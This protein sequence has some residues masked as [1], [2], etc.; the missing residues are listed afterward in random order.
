RDAALSPGRPAYGVGAGAG[1]HPV[2]A[3][4]RQHGRTPH[5]QG[6]GRRGDRRRRPHRRERR[7]RKQDRHLPARGAGETPWHSVL[8]RRALLHF[9]SE[10]P[11]RLPYSY[12]GAPGRRGP[13]LSRR[14]LGAAGRFSAQSRLRRDAGR[15]DHRHHL[16][17]GDRFSTLSG[18]YRRAYEVTALPK[19]V[20]LYA[21]MYAAYGVASPFLPA[22][23]SGRGLSPQEIGVALA[24]GTAVRLVSAPLAGR[25]ADL[26][27]ALRVMLVVSIAAA[28][29]VTL[30]Y[31]SVRGF[32]MALAVM[33][34]HA[35]ALAP[36]TVL[37]DALALG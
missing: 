23:V 29:L 25:I 32:W 26:V 37:A 30:G 16:R 27:Q 18:E 34:L 11:G 8:R 31:L 13:R 15:A 9:R 35:W 20:A 10:N 36:M 7:R 14:A 4:H 5:E 17:E 33:V 22:F 28:A 3:H 6:R 19:F 24:A 2:H 12:R 21:A 1:R